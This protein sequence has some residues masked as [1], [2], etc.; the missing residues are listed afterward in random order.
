MLFISYHTVRVHR[1]NI[2]RKLN[3]NGKF[4]AVRIAE[5]MG[6]I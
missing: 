2:F 3:A 6:W 4:H 1:V 5:K